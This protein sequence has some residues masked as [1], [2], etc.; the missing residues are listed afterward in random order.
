DF[1]KQAI[2]D[3]VAAARAYLAGAGEPIPDQP[4][5]SLV[6]A[7]HQ[8]DLFHPGVW[9]KNFMLSS[10]G[11][12]HATGAL[13]LIVDNDA[14]KHTATSVPVV[15]DDP[16][17]VKRAIVAYDAFSSP[18][19]FEERAIHDEAEFA[20]FPRRVGELTRHWPAQPILPQFWEAVMRLHRR[21]RLIGELFA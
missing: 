8:P 19:P 12:R 13:N 5:E 2:S 21:T 10:I 7:G 15:A 11:R 1:R 6:I 14:V 16:A 20:D 3:A 4:T 18:A 9:L 17:H